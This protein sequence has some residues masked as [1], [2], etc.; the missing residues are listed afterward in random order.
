MTKWIVQSHSDSDKYFVIQ[1]PLPLIINND[2]VDSSQVAILAEYVA[3]VLN[4]HWTPVPACFCE[5]AICAQSFRAI[6]ARQAAEQGMKCTGCENELTT[7]IL[8]Q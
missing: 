5:N 3:A 2:D 4:Q 1:G 6:P 7:R 8:D